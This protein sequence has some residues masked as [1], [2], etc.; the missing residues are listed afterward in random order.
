MPISSKVTN[1]SGRKV[2][3]SILHIPQPAAIGAHPVSLVFG[4]TTQLCAGVQKLAQ[5]YAIIL[6]SNLG[7]QVEYPR[8]GT[9]FLLT[10][11]QGLS[12]VDAMRARQIFSL[13][14]YTASNIIKNYQITATD[15]PQD[16]QLS[17]SSLIDIVMYAG[18]ISFSVQITTL[19]GDI[20][21]FLIPLP[22]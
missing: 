13:A 20:I 11:Q 5:R 18:S 19:A 14:N 4:K 22:E 7:S 1:Y 10:L 17:S 21:D 15:L 9:S 8:F 16:E 3:V 2:D 6:L 12:P